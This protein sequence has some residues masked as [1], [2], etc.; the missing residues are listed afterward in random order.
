MTEDGDHFRCNP[1][2]LR[3]A[4]ATAT[5]FL[6][7]NAQGIA[8]IMRAKLTFLEQLLKR[9]AQPESTL[10]ERLDSFA[11]IGETARLLDEEATAFFDLASQPLLERLLRRTS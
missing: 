6:N 11:R 9:M 3:R 10:E 7:E 8:Q 1:E 5:Q 4:Q 2:E